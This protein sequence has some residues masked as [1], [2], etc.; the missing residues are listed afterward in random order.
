MKIKTA[1]ILCAG[2][3]KRLAPLTS[4]T[5]K[6]LLMLNDITI[7]ESCINTVIKLG[8]NKIFLNTFHLGEKVS[9]FIKNQ[10]F[11][12]DIQLIKDGDEILN[13]GGGILNMINHSDDK[14]FLVFNPDTLWNES[15]VDEI[16]DMQNLYFKNQLTNILMV[17]NKQLSFDQNLKGDFEL[18]KNLL[19]KENNKNFI[20]IG[21]QILKKDL[22]KNYK[23]KSFSISEI[24]KE[25]LKKNE[26]NGFE[27]LIKFYHLTNLE[28]FK[29]LKDF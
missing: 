3:G 25:L 11:P 4:K 9:N 28:I 6:P 29:K 22:F 17:T 24:W 10:S 26:L 21:C 14:D 12:V 13:T 16:N 18:K 5:P 20:Y 7:L 15:Y 23:V 1:L 27:S 2:L 8:I 19:K